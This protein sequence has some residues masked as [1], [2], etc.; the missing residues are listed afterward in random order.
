MKIK[1]EINFSLYYYGTHHHPG[2]LSFGSVNSYTKI[3]PP[4]PMNF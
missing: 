1:T 3:S 2:F 4:L